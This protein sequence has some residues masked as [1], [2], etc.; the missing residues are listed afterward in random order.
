MNTQL[1]VALLGTLSLITGTLLAAHDTKRIDSKPKRS[2]E[3]VPLG[4]LTGA[5]LAANEYQ[6]D[7]ASLGIAS[8]FILLDCGGGRRDRVD[9]SPLL[10]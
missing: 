1:R 10:P 9:N 5:A 3:V 8:D 7:I 4:P 6:L 2:E